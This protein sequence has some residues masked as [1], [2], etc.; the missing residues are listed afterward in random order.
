MFSDCSR[1]VLISSGLHLSREVPAG[2]SV[3]YHSL[4][5]GAT[6]TKTIAWS[7]LISYRESN[8]YYP[9]R[10]KSQFNYP[11]GCSDGLGNDEDSTI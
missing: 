7:V 10:S 8:T 1:M 3:D 6:G 4:G 5:C 2:D 11:D 9:N